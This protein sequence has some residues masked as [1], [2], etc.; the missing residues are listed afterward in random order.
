MSET[1]TK[2]PEST[3]P[4]MAIGDRAKQFA[5]FAALGKLDDVLLQMELQRNIGDPE[6]VADLS[7][8]SIEE[9]TMML[10]ENTYDISED[11]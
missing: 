3:H 9:A 4:K 8:L 10:A 2:R 1:R 11:F 6:H 7:D 5:P